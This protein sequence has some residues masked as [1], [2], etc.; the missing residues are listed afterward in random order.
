LSEVLQFL[1]QDRGTTAN[2]GSYVAGAAVARGRNGPAAFALGDGTVR[3]LAPG[4]EAWRTAPVHEGAIL[5]FGPA[6]GGFVT[7][8]DDG[9]FCLV[10]PDGAVQEVAKFG[11]RWVE[12]VAC[13]GDAQENK[14]GGLLA[15]SAGK[16]AHVFDVGGKPLKQLAHPSTVTGLAFDAK[17]KRL[18]ASHYGGASLWFVAAR[19]DKPRLLAWKGSH[20]GIAIHPGGEAVVTSM[21]ENALHGWRLSDGQ[22]M[23]MS[24]YP[25]KTE[26]LSFSRTG[27][28]L[29]SS[30]A[31]SVVLWP[32]FGGGPMGKPPVELAGGDGVL[33]A[34][35]AFHPQQDIVADGFSDGL[36]ALADVATE[37][38]LPV[39]P[40]GHGAITALAWSADSA[41]LA[42]GTEQGFAALV[43][44]SKR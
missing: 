6:P 23:R 19:E 40:P 26:S 4:G 29:A 9:R 15:C 35:V 28:W 44:L 22:H 27:R 43:D 13:Y 39:A 18:G 5:A 8:G 31:E 25:A 7:G 34:R 17:G 42:F 32:F 14:G 41:W 3:L 37:R 2:L 36:V 38:V 33:C 20:T 24:G 10:G 16:Q 12:Q 30:G 1:L 11:G 21:Q